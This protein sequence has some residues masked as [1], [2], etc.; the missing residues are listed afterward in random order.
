MTSQLKPQY[1]LPFLMKERRQREKGNDNE[2]GN[3]NDYNA[4]KVI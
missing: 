4:K 3:M 2:R 1:I